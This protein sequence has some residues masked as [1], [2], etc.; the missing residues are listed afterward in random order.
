MRNPFEWHFIKWI[1][2]PG[3]SG[4]SQNNMVFVSTSSIPVYQGIPNN[5]WNLSFF[6]SIPV[7]R[8]YNNRGP[9]A[10][11][12]HFMTKAPFFTNQI[13]YSSC[14]YSR[15]F[16]RVTFICWALHETKGR[17]WTVSWDKKKPEKKCS[18]CLSR[19]NYWA[20]LEIF[21]SNKVVAKVVRGMTWGTYYS[22]IVLSDYLLHYF[23]IF[24]ALYDFLLL[25]HFQ[26]WWW[27]KYQKIACHTQYSE[28]KK[29]SAKQKVF[30]IFFTLHA[31]LRPHWYSQIFRTL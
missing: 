5:R 27:W 18:H 24:T 4:I 29:N 13:R 20:F 3:L 1:Q 11:L 8:I 23:Y 12:W 2:F 31:P 16:S 21:F 25:S 15:A 17:A 19:N 28:I 26:R 6:I 10:G 22:K 7:L 30:K 14:V 9:L